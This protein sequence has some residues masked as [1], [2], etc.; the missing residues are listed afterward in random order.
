MLYFV[1]EV[2]VW[3]LKNFLFEFIIGNILKVRDLFD[4]D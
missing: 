1:G 4:L 3:C 2:D